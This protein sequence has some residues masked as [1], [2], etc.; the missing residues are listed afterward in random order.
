MGTPVLSLNTTYMV[1]AEY[2][3]GSPGSASLYE[4]PTIGASQPAANVTLNGNGTVSTID[5]IG[6]KAQSSSTT[7]TFLVDNAIVGTTW[8]DVT[9]Q[10]VP[11]PSSLALAA[12]GLLGVA[13]RL[14][15]PRA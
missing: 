8:A 11:E 6:F 7:G 4:N 14:R 1:V 10:A 13:A 5:D 12:V 3:F 15:R 9:P 2:T